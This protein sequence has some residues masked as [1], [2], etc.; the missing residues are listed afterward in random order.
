MY[1]LYEAPEFAAIKAVD[2]QRYRDGQP[3]V[4]DVG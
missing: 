3:N 2:A 1:K 4:L